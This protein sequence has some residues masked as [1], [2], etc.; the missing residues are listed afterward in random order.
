MLWE[1]MDQPH[2]FNIEAESVQAS[3]LFVATDH[4]IIEAAKN[5]G[6]DCHE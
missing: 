2:F 4:D 1:Y 6:Y 3:G 5:S